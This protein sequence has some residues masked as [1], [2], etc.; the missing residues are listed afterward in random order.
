T[1]VFDEGLLGD[2]FARAASRIATYP[3][4]REGTDSFLR[5]FGPAEYHSA[6]EYERAVGT[7]IGACV[8]GTE[9]SSAEVGGVTVRQRR[10][11]D[12]PDAE[13]NYHA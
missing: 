2:D 8:I 4:V 9:P 13:A 7:P 12:D 6:A 5:E 1:V 10:L 11:A 3:Y